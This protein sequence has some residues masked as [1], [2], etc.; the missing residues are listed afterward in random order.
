MKNIIRDKEENNIITTEHNLYRR[1]TVQSMDTTNIEFQNTFKQKLKT[2][3]RNK[4]NN[5][6]LIF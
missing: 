2:N 5:H 6:N 1:Q 4:I 3:L